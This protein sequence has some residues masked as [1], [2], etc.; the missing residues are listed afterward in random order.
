M[1]PLD[2]LDR[3]CPEFIIKCDRR[4]SP[5]LPIEKATAGNRHPEHFLQAHR[6]PTEQNFVR[7]ML[8][9]LVSIVS[10]VNTIC[11]LQ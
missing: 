5:R 2:G 6:L 8:L 7:A 11:P 1:E 3:D 9:R 4:P 10:A